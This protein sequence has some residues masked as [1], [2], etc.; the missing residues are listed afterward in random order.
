MWPEILSWI[1]GILAMLFFFLIYQQTKREK[2]LFCKLCADVSWT[3]HYLFLGA[4]GGAIP[5][6]VGIFR[7]II[8]MLRSR[9]K[10]ANSKLLPLLFVA[11]NLGLGIMTFKNPINIMPIMASVFVTLSLWVKNPKIT[12]LITIPVCITFLIYD[13]FVNS[14]IG[15][16][17]ESISIVSILIYFIR[18]E[19]KMDEKKNDAIIPGAPIEDYVKII[20]KDVNEEC[21]KR[22]DAFAD[23]I[24]DRFFAD[25][26]KEGDQMVHVTTYAYIGDTVYMTYY[27]NPKS[28]EEN[29][30][31]QIAR[32]VYCKL[33][34][35][36]NKTY[37]DL[38]G[39]GDVYGDKIVD[40]VYDTILM[41]DDDKTLYLMW[42]AKLSGNYYRLYRTFD[43][44][45]KTLGEIKINTLTVQGE[46]IDFSFS[47]IQRIFTETGVGYKKMFA[48]IGIMQKCSYRVEE[49]KRFYYTGAYSGDFNF[50][51]KSC[52]FEN[53]EYVSQP[54]FINDSMWENA[55][56]VLDD[57]CYYFVRQQ[58][59]SPYGFLTYLDLNTMKWARP[60][61]VED[62]QSRADFIMYNDN[63]YVFFAP[64]DREHLG[65][66]WV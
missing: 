13:V 64:I 30:D 27:A 45:S 39:A 1:F 29:P 37:I 66:V 38:Q 5:N 8:F 20:S 49:G 14:Y 31:F 12:K 46:K 58:I 34:E 57:K 51:M 6:F 44:E 22:G 26:K 4:V 16:V 17:N 59:E 23:E 52:D 11:I 55:V 43:V 15:I 36:E 18:G 61:L 24:R 40:C 2:L 21:I 7:E 9:Y 41:R 35:P 32:L 50:I 63:L 62:S 3:A 33:D 54:D 25:F 65:V 10:W 53:W 28:P 56:Y 42:T 47:E 60:V 19:K 48:D